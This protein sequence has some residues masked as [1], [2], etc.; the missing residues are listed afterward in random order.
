MVGGTSRKPKVTP[1]LPRLVVWEA[2]KNPRIT[3]KGILNNLSNA[4][5]N[6]SSSIDTNKGGLHF[7]KTGTEKLV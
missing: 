7:F 4:D 6:I 3:S 5:N 1:A 2:K